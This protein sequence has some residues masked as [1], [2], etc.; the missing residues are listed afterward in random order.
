MSLFGLYEN[1][2]L[3]HMFPRKVFVI[4]NVRTQD[5]FMF[6][7]GNMLGSILARILADT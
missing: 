3:P 6:Q 4:F 1:L 7:G 2:Q 5:T